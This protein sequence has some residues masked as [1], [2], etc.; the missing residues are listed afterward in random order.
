MRSRHR[1]T[2]AALALALATAGGAAAQDVGFGAGT[3]ESRYFRID[4]A[5]VAGRHGPQV[6][7]YVYNL[8]DITAVMVRLRIEALEGAGGPIDTRDVWLPLDVP[9]RGRAFFQAKVPAAATSAR[10]SVQSFQWVPRGP[11]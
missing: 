9:G 3:P 4:A 6:E 5:V 11:S 1:V 10:V 2:L 7:G 8:Y